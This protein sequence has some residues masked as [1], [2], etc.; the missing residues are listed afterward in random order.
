MT[1][2]PL[3]VS[4]SP[5][6][7]G[8]DPV[9]G[10]THTCTKGV[11]GGN[12]SRSRDCRTCDLYAKGEGVRSVPVT[13]VTEEPRDTAPAPQPTNLTTAPPVAPCKWLGEPDATC[14]TCP[15][16]TKYHCGKWKACTLA[17]VGSAV[18]NCVRCRSESLGYEP[19]VVDFDTGT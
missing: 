12:V 3:C 2:R 14:K 1:R 7:T 8:F 17:P 11:C 10:P 18:M 19:L 9:K 13:P 15:S 16:K 6:C 4:C 5:A